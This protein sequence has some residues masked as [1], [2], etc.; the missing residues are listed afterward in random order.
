MLHPDAHMFFNG[1]IHEEEVDVMNAIMT[2]L[3]LKVGLKQWGGSAEAAL[4]SEMK[5]LHYRDTFEPLHYA[6]LTRKEKDE[7]LETHMFLKKKRDG[8][9]KGRT[10]ADGKPWRQSL[11]YS[12]AS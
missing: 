10:V 12:A 1:E 7:I 9:I 11:F 3:S 6:K 2:Q 5:Q 4:H 8:K